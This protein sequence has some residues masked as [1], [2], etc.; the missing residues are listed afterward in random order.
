MIISAIGEGAY[1]GLYSLVGLGALIWLGVAF[2][3]A[4]GGP[5]DAVYWAGNGVTR[6]VQLVI[7]FL[8]F[9]LAVPG[10]M[11]R[12][13]TS[14]GQARTA[15]DADTITGMLRISRHPF[16]WG[17]VIWAL[18]HILVN[19]DAACLVFFGTFL[20]LGLVGPVSIDAKRQRALG[21]TWNEF[22]NKTSSVPFG[23]IASGRQ[24]LNVGEIGFVR[25][26]AGPIVFLLVLGAHS[27][28]FG[29]SPLP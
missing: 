23:A 26:A 28:I 2:S 7:Q 10:L 21:P 19:G 16:L 3:V 1:M 24:T 12:N 5:G 27:H 9:M 6:T 22:A 17:V 13:P 4:R 14:I 15:E 8:A 11:T 20:V 25:L 29:S 18:G